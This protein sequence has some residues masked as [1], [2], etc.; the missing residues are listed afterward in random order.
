MSASVIR[1]ALLERVQVTAKIPLGSRPKP[2][3]LRPSLAAQ[4]PRRVT[5]G[6]LLVA[7]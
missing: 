6:A 1:P 2:T 3:T 7:P 4:N 5:L